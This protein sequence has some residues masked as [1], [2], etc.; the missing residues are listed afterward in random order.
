MPQAHDRVE[1]QAPARKDVVHSAAGQVED[2][3]VAV[4]ARGTW[5]CS[6]VGLVPPAARRAALTAEGLNVC[7]CV[8]LAY[9]PVAL[10]LP[11]LQ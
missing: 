5:P 6:H 11:C 3:G 9:K 4:L 7:G 2:A 10:V 8:Y 1:R